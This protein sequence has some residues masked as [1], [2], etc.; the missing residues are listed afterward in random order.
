MLMNISTVLGLVVGMALSL[1]LSLYM[2][3]AM[4]AFYL[5][6]YC[7]ALPKPAQKQPLDDV[8]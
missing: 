7:G 8:R 2:N 1:L 4:A 5:K 3:T 6:E